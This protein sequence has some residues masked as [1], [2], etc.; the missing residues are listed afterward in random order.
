MSHRSPFPDIRVPVVPLA[1]YI[2]EN[3][4]SYP[5]KTAIVD[6]MSGRT[7]TYGAL[8]E[9]VRRVAAGL[10]ARGFSLGLAAFPSIQR[11]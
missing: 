2:F 8:C 6:A 11:G 5:D 4:G 1:D 10:A 9:L 7:L 3:A